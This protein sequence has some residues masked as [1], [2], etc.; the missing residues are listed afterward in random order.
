MTGLELEPQE[1]MPLFEVFQSPDGMFCYR[2]FC[3]SISG[4]APDASLR[5]GGVPAMTA[6]TCKA[7]MDEKMHSALYDLE[8]QLRRKAQVRRLDLRS[9]LEGYHRGRPGHLARAQFARI[10]AMHGFRLTE[11]QLNMICRAYCDTHDQQEL[12][13]HLFCASMEQPRSRHDTSRPSSQ[14]PPAGAIPGGVA[15]VP[16][17]RHAIHHDSRAHPQAAHPPTGKAPR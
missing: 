10:M 17:S 4:E 3:A 16:R 9:T 8:A 13:F 6:T 14:A 1:Y 2:D 5:I 12:N 11:D 15:V 7:E